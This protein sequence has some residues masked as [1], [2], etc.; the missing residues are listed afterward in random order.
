L[1]VADADRRGIIRREGN[2]TAVLVARKGWRSPQQALV[3]NRTSGGL[4]LAIQQDVPV[5]II[6]W[7]RACNAPENTPWAEVFVRWCEQSDGYFEVGCQFQGKLPWSV[8]LMFG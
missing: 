2:R 1:P 3:L 4:R 5:G 6:L 7:L 8:L